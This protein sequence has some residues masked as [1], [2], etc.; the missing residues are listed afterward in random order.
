MS[1]VVLLTGASGFIGRAIYE[2]LVLRGHTVRA[3]TRRA[4]SPGAG[5]E[6][7]EIDGIDGTTDWR[8]GLEG[9]EVVIH[10]AARVHVM[11]EREAEPLVAFRR[12]N[13]DGT[14]NLARQA[15]AAG[16]RRFIF[17]S[18][19][20][21]NGEA[22]LPGRPYCADDEPAPADPYAISKMEAEAGLRELARGTDLDV[23][24]IR[25]VL[26]Y[27]PGVKANFLTMMR[28][29]NKGIPLPFGAI[30]N[31]RS[32]VALENLVD[33]VHRCMTHPAVANQTFL[34]SD[35][36]DLSTTC[37]LR[38]MAQ[39]LGKPARLV[40]VPGRVL[41]LG[42]NLLGRGALAQRLCGSLQVDIEKTRSLLDWTPPVSVDQ[43][44]AQ[45]ASHYREHLGE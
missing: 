3:A 9:V 1:S 7:F 5:S 39:A 11:N 25:P 4:A 38:R 41:T 36:D 17:I 8:G 22:T 23:V 26:V 21:V 6:V 40:P 16:V 45:T 32:L 43:A 42:A 33:L 12:V 18:S 35:G 27:G 15:A 44:L 24:I 29:L 13:V 19:I 28:W 31:R 14:V 20:K 30:D 2:D 37:L 34:V 10:S